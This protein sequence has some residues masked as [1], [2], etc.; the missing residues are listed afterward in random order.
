MEPSRPS[1][2]HVLMSNARAASA[3][4]KTTTSTSSSSPKKRKLGETRTAG[5][6]KTLVSKPVS[7]SVKPK[8]DSLSTVEDSKSRALIKIAE[9]K[10]RIGFLKSN[11][12]SFDPESVAWWEKG[13]RVPFMFLCLVFDLIS[14]ENNRKSGRIV[15]TDVLCNMLRTVIA[16]TP[17]N[18]IATVYLAANEIAPVHEGVELGIVKS[19]ITKAISEAFNRSDAQVEQLLKTELAD[20]WLLVT[21]SRSSQATVFNFK[22]KP[23]TI[24]K[25][26]DTFR[27]IAKESGKDSQ[28]NKKNRITG[29]LVETT[30]CE[31]L[32]LTRLLEGNLRLGF[33][34]KIVLAAL[35]Q[36]AVYNEEHSK[37]PPNIKSPLEE[38]AKIVKRVY[39]VLP[40]YDMIVHALLTGGV[41]NLTKTCNLTLGVPIR[42]M[43]VKVIKSIDQILNNFEGTVFTCEYKYD[44]ERVQIHYME[45]GIFEIYSRNGERSTGK[46]PDVARAFK[47]SKKASV[48]SF[49]L[50]C[51]VV[52]F[53]REE[54]KILPFQILSTR[55]RKNVKVSDIKVG[56]CI[57]AFD[58]LYLNCQQLIQENLDIR[59]EKLYNSFEEDLG[60]FQF[61][62]AL[63]SSDTDDIEEFFEASV[64]IGIGDSVD[65]VPIGAFHGKGKRAGLF[66]SFLLA[67]YDKKKEEFQSICKIGTGFSEAELKELY[68]LLS[69]HMIAKP[70][71][72]YFVLRSSLGPFQCHICIL[73]E[74]LL[75]AMCQTIQHD[76]RVGDSDKPHVWFEP[77]EVWEV[78]GADLTISPKYGAAIGIVV[79]DKGISLRFPR[80]IR[81]RKDKKPKE[82][83]SS[84]QIAEMFQAQKNNHP[85]NQDESDDD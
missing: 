30:D 14:I 79:P 80:L 29:L 32:Y 4:K 39:S 69:S 5:S 61:V 81:V 31:T 58:M 77:T 47:R 38:A 73:T 19:S 54:K 12:D 72:G 28:R 21:E 24:V 60:Y 50:D 82:A 33:S 48:K 85:S 76:Y 45:D 22:P 46:Y 11:P 43:L 66:G 2:H 3:K 59:R 10:N 7:D 68:S 67:C 63:T 27:Q 17:E 71:V 57:F 16:T 26:F 64:D 18:L 34:G 56:V 40:V 9:L 20:L 78:K 13:E 37:P 52:A 6:D 74:F 83:T 55:A 23:L 44:G 15:I 75:F 8:S 49:I 36:A 70:Q 35:G 51:E 84:K 53:D 62:T 41:W 65:L 42:P 25:V 1:A